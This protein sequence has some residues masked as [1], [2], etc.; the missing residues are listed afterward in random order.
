MKKGIVNYVI[1]LLNKMDNI[2]PFH[3]D[4]LAFLVLLLL[5]YHGYISC[6]NDKIVFVRFSDEEIV[7]K[8]FLEPI[9]KN[10]KNVKFWINYYTNGIC[11]SI[12]K[13]FNYYKEYLDSEK[14]IKI[15][16]KLFGLKKITRTN[17]FDFI[18]NEIE[19]KIVNERLNNYDDM[20]LYSIGLAK[21]LIDKKSIEESNKVKLKEFI[22]EN[23][24]MKIIK[25]SELGN[26]LL[27][28]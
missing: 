15:E 25:N 13:L 7:N 3:Q 17:E 24:I 26:F 22:D 20:I 18:I 10:N 12:P 28:Y 11:Q 19:D 2:Q 8:Y 9:S 16:K 27:F 6:Q 23:N 1:L 14:I 21:N 4:G 5:K